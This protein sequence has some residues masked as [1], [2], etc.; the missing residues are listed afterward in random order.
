MGRTSPFRWGTCTYPVWFNETGLP[1]GV[2]WSV[3]IANQTY[4][5]LNGS[6]GLVLWNGSYPY[7]ISAVPGYHLSG[8]GYSGSVLVSAPQR[9]AFSWARVVYPITAT[10][11]GLSTGIP[12][13]IAVA[14]STYRST[15]GTLSLSLSNGTYP[16]TVDVA[17]VYIATDPSDLLQVAGHAVSFQ[18]SFVPRYATL[19]GT[20][21]PR[22]ATVALNGTT[23]ETG[24]S[25]FRMEA[26][27]GT[28]ELTAVLSG[29]HPYYA[30]VTLTPGNTTVHNI[31]L[32]A[33]PGSPSNG[34]SGSPSW[35]GGWTSTDA[36][37]GAAILIVGVVAVVAVL[38]ARP[39]RKR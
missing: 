28:Y 39:S 36:L 35:L 8:L 9:L 5:T 2:P 29:Y 17:Y 7:S 30:N 24:E 25:S 15:N 31:A 14:N 11:D 23:A 37:L 38:K 16:Y 4:S 34:T 12:W 1:E 19:S 32:V 22:G 20:V 3:T 13:S 21:T 26:L 10:S 6:I 33:L 27:A 18:V